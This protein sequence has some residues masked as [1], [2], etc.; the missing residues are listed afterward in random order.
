MGEM[1]GT[2]GQSGRARTRAA[3]RV[4]T[5]A[6]GGPSRSHRVTLFRRLLADLRSKRETT[7]VHQSTI[8]NGKTVTYVRDWDGVLARPPPRAAH[9]PLRPRGGW[10]RAAKNSARPTGARAAGEQRAPYF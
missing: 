9:W 8:Y 10:A 4:R 1:L 2:R 5:E 3:A 7:S 6:R